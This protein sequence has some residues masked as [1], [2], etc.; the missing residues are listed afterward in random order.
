MPPT[1]HPKRKLKGPGVEESGGVAQTTN[2]RAV[3]IVPRVAEKGNNVARLA[4]VCKSLYSNSRFA[5]L[6]Q[7][8]GQ[9]TVHCSELPYLAE[10]KKSALQ[11]TLHYR[12]MKFP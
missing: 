1:K 3:C 9:S 11:S 6:P 2:K 5:V 7:V 8:H 12:L 10:N 4:N